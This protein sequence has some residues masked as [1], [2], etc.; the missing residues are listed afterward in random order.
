[1]GMMGRG[2]G[3]DSPISYA[4]ERRGWASDTSAAKGPFLLL[5]DIGYFS[6]LSRPRSL[7]CKMGHP[8]ITLVLIFP[9]VGLLTA[10]K[11]IRMLYGDALCRASNVNNGQWWP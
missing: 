9:K 1:M 8:L 10:V 5:S 7:C 6:N 3:R 11:S 4:A 2:L